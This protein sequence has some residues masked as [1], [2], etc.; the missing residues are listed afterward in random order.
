MKIFILFLAIILSILS[1]YNLGKAKYIAS[2]IHMIIWQIFI[3]M[4][5]CV[6]LRQIPSY[7]GILFLEVMCMLVVLGEAIGS[8]YSMPLAETEFLE[9]SID[10]NILWIL[11]VI[12]T[13][14]GIIQQI[15]FVYDNGFNFFDLTHISAFLA[16]SNQMAVTRYSTGYAENGGVLS[17]IISVF[18]YTS[19]LLG[20]FLFD[21]SKSKKE[22]FISVMSL[23]PLFLGTMITNAKT[24]LIAGVFLFVIGLLAAYS[25]NKKIESFFTLKRV[26]AVVILLLLFFVLLLLTFCFRLGSLSKDSF[27]IAA[28]KFSIYFCGQIHSFSVWMAARGNI[29]PTLGAYTFIGIASKFGIIERNSGVFDFLP[30]TDSNIF[31]AFRG[32][33]TDYTVVGA[34]AIMLF[35]GFLLGMSYK[36]VKNTGSAFAVALWSSIVFFLFYDFIISA[37]TYM[38]YILVFPLFWIIL[39]LRKVKVTRKQYA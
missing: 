1:V 2:S 5:F 36:T 21:F 22:K 31:T 8:R 4:H 32:M 38:S 24:G 12:F 23:F 26:I 39:C 10:G 25:C 33:I 28:E 7:E 13:I 11:L 35:T 27:E 16:M 20:G 18:I 29:D 37:W 30:G 6:S 9:G 14:V 19:P 3:I 17:S 34:L 15:V